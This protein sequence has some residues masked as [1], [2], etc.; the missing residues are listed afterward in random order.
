MHF[1]LF[2]FCTRTLIMTQTRRNDRV[3]VKNRQ[4]GGGIIMKHLLPSIED[5]LQTNFSLLSD[6]DDKNEAAYIF[7]QHQSEVWMLTINEYLHYKSENI[8]ELY[9]KKRAFPMKKLLFKT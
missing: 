5:L 6:M 3:I 1:I 4:L 2:Y 8:K 9:W 7:K